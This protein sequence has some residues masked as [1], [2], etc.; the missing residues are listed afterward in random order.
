MGEETILHLIGN[1]GVPAVFAFYVLFDVNKNIKRLTE[2]IDRFSEEIGRRVD[3]LD[4]EVIHRVDKLQDNINTLTLE[5]KALSRGVSN[6]LHRH[7]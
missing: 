1:V 2:S 7:E 3:K 6:D 5:V 4:N